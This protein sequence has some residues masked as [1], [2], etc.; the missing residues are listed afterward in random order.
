MKPYPFDVRGFCLVVLPHSSSNLEYISRLHV[1]Y[2]LQNKEWF[3]AIISVLKGLS[4]E[5]SNFFK[6]LW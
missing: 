5:L 2:L 6:Y 1:W 4:S 3:L